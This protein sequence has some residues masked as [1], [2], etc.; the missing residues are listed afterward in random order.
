[1]KSARAENIKL[2][3][4]QKAAEA[5]REAIVRQHE[6]DKKEQLGELDEQIANLKEQLADFREH[7]KAAKR[8]KRSK[9]VVDIGGGHMIITEEASPG[10][11][12]K[13]GRRRRRK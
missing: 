1:M 4:Q 10:Q 9:K 2:S 12:R 3:K 13:K 8:I 6:A 7:A 11:G 5:G